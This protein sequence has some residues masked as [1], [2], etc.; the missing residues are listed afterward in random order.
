MK[1]C[2]LHLRQ[3]E[4]ACTCRLDDVMTD[5]MFNDYTVQRLIL[6]QYCYAINVSYTV[7]KI[8]YTETACRAR[9]G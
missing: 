6:L 9:K 3:E 7:Q 8:K 4:K 5:D 2:D 1:L